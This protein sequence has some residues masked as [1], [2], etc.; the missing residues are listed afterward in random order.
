MGTPPLN[1]IDMGTLIRTLI[2][3]WV[4]IR[5]PMSVVSPTPNSLIGH[6]KPIYCN[7]YTKISIDKRLL[8]LMRV[9]AN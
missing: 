1:S 9:Q 7:S 2:V 3:L 6:L 5:L 8:L 4:L